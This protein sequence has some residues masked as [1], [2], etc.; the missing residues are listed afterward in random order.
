MR[1]C[2]Y[3]KLEGP[4]ALAVLDLIGEFGTTNKIVTR[5][6]VPEAHRGKGIASTLLKEC[7]EEADRTKTVLKLEVVPTGGLTQLQLVHW[8]RRNGFKTTAG[9]VMVRQPVK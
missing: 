7:C 2:F 6:N 8:Y 5:I 1:G 4:T 3:E 9:N